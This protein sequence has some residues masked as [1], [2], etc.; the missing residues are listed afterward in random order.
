MAFP[1]TPAA[2]PPFTGV[3]AVTQLRLDPVLA[4]VL[5]LAAGLYLYGVARLRA[6]GD[7]WPAARTVLFLVAG[8]GSIAAVTMSGLGTYDDTLL[9]AHMIQHMVLTMLAP[10]FLALGAPVTLA[11]RTLPVRGRR[12]LVA[13]LHSRVAKVLAFPLV[14]YA[15]FVVTPFALYFTP[16]YRLTLEHNWLHEWVHVHFV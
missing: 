10:I 5:V 12:V 11:L 2:L 7:R 3:T 16:L 4:L 14:A 9:S 1:G 13:V 15:L 6:R 8:L